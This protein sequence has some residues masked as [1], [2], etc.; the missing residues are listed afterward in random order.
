[1]YERIILLAQSNN[2]YDMLIQFLIMARKTLKD[3]KIDSELI[4]AYS[5]GGDK[6]LTDLE[7]MIAEPNQADLLKCGERCFDDK[8]YLAAE[9]LFK[10]SANHQKLAVTY[11]RLKKYQAA[12]EAAK[13]V[14]VPKVWKQVCFACVRA[15]EFR[16]AALCGQ[17]VIIHQDHL[18]DIIN[19]YEKFGYI[20]ELCQLLEQG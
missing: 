13:K 12:F 2:E 1:M 8:A 6:F 10:R 20:T 16:M 4:I 7:A 9:L 14:G 17:N 3:N 19:F 5:K 15:K 11:V 18:E